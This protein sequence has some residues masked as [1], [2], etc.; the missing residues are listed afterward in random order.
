VYDVVS[1]LGGCDLGC[2]LLSPRLGGVRLIATLSYCVTLA[3]GIVLIAPHAS[4]DVTLPI[5]PQL[6]PTTTLI[7]AATATDDS[8]NTTSGQTTLTVVCGNTL[9]YAKSVANGN[10]VQLVGLVATTSSSDFKGVF[11]AEHADR[12][13]GIGIMWTGSVSRGDIVSVT[14]MALTMHGERFVLAR[15]VQSTSASH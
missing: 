15:A 5:V 8:G 4:C 7:I 2:S 13:G 12:S 3:V 1:D 6:P 10:S 14:G 11:Y 9:Q